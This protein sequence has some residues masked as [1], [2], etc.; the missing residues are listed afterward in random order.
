MNSDTAI[1]QLS[2][3]DLQK[4]FNAIAVTRKLDATN[5]AVVAMTFTAMLLANQYVPGENKKA[6]R[7]KCEA[8]FGHN[9]RFHMPRVEVS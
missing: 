4:S 3:E 6:Y 5:A 8:S 9:L 2:L 7:A 1:E